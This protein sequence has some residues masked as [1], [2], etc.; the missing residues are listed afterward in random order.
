MGPGIRKAVSREE[1]AA[2]QLA[3]GEM[4]GRRFAEHIGVAHGT[5]KRWLHEG[6]PARRDG[7]KVW[8]TPDEARAWIEV[9]FAG[10]VTVAF[11]RQ[12][13][14]VYF[15]QAEGGLLKIGWSSDVMRR[16][17]EL[18]KKSRQAVELLACFPGDKPDELRVHARFARL[19]VGGE[20]YRDDGSIAD[21]LAT[22][23]GRAA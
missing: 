3:S 22:L 1:R 18:R 21:Y 2:G 7:N 17:A 16:V 10:K 6:M 14:L 8:I 5:V 9:R 4:N 13:S 11:K 12:T 20:W 15:A 23:A 19:H